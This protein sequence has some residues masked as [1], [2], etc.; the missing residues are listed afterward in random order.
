MRA[1]ETK[2]AGFDATLVAQSHVY[3]AYGSA[4]DVPVQATDRE[5]DCKTGLSRIGIIAPSVSGCRDPCL[6]ASRTKCKSFAWR[7][8]DR[9]VMGRARRVGRVKSI[10]MRHMKGE[11]IL[12]G[13]ESN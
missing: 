11:E 13:S 3:S 7:R 12:C 8:G 6:M 5:Y 1:S 10:W 2:K 9:D 4:C